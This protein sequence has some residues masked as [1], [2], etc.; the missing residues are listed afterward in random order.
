MSHRIMYNVINVRNACS[1]FCFAKYRSPGI[2]ESA[3]DNGCGCSPADIDH[4]VLKI[5]PTSLGHL[6]REIARFQNRKTWVFVLDFFEDVNVDVFEALPYQNT[7][8]LTVEGCVHFFYKDYLDKID[9]LYK[10]G[11]REVWLGVESANADLRDSYN[12]PSFTNEQLKEIC[13]KLRAGGIGYSW[14]LVHGPEDTPK[15]YEQTNELTRELMPDLVWYSQL[16]YAGTDCRYS[17]DHVKG[18]K[19]TTW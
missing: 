8:P 4:H 9:E 19:Q 11:I 10:K 3:C 7:T 1:H 17:A 12:K 5:E 14:Y 2:S 13:R 6:P 15:T 18:E 16:N